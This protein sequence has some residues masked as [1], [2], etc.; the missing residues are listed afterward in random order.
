MA[1]IP[2][3]PAR[4]RRIV[5]QFSAIGPD[6]SPRMRQFEKFDDSVGQGNELHAI[7]IAV[8]ARIAGRITVDLRAA[9]TPG[10]VLR[11]KG[12][13]IG[14]L[15]ANGRF[16]FVFSAF[17]K[18]RGHSVIT[19]TVEAPNARNVVRVEGMTGDLILLVRLSSVCL[20]LASGAGF[21]SQWRRLRR[22]LAGV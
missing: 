15:L 18:R 3:E 14:I 17:R 6:R 16:L 5:R 10:C 1:D 13:A 11:M 21:P 22:N 20:V 4:L 8:E 12:S 9:A 19:Q 2:A 7:V